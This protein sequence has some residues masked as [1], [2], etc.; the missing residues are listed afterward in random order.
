MSDPDPNKLPDS[1]DSSVLG[2]P[3]PSKPIPLPGP[4][5]TTIDG[6]VYVTDDE[7]SKAAENKELKGNKGD[8]ESGSSK[9]ARKQVSFDSEIN[10]TAPLSDLD[11]EAKEEA[12]KAQ[13]NARKPPAKA[14]AYK[15]LS[16]ACTRLAQT[17]NALATD[18]LYSQHAG[19]RSRKS[20][21][22]TIPDARAIV[23]RHRFFSN[24]V[25][26]YF[27]ETDFVWRAPKDHDDEF[28]ELDE[29]QI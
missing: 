28:D 3:D 2:A 21:W 12:F 5:P 6:D 24:I 7:S 4:P 27:L 22:F 19:T 9:K 8:S 14:E 16:D 17:A 23:K 1:A 13:R 20:D 11:R 10:V 26:P 15:N 18:S 29:K 25:N